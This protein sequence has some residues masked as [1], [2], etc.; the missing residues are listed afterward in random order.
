MGIVRP[1]YG[2]ACAA[3]RRALRER[4]KARADG[5][6]L[7]MFVERGLAAI[8]DMKPDLLRAIADRID[9]AKPET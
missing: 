9:P 5:D 6:E 3:A 2:D 4:F 7:E 8:H 1:E